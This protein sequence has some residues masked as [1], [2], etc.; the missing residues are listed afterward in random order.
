ML[1][2]FVQYVSYPLWERANGIRDLA[3]LRQLMAWEKLDAEGLRVL[4]RE[5]LRA[6]L[7]H[8]ND[9]VPFYREWFAAHGLR[10]QDFGEVDA[11]RL[12][13]PLTKSAISAAG[14]QMISTSVP[15]NTVRRD[16]TGGST[17]EPLYFY[18]NEARKS[19]VRALTMRENLWLGCR[20]GDRIA[21]FWGSGKD[22]QAPATFRNTMSAV[23]VRRHRVFNAYQLTD[24][25]VDHFL[26]G[27]DSY[28]PVLIVAYARAMYAAACRLQ[29]TGRTPYRPK[30]IVI[31]AESVSDE[32][33]DVIR[34][35]FA[36]PVVNRYAS[37]EVGQVASGCGRSSLLHVNDESVVVQLEPL[38]GAAAGDAGRLVTTDLAN[39]VMPL[40]RYDTGDH[41][42]PAV[43]RC[44]CGRPSTVLGGVEGRI[45]DLFARVDGGR[46][47]G[48]AFVHLFRQ[49]QAIKTFQ[50]VQ[51]SLRDVEV[52]LVLEAPL[53][54]AEWQAIE[55]GIR[56][57]LGSRDVG[58]RRS[59]C[60]TIEPPISGKH[61]FAISRV[62]ET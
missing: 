40:I 27:L 35:A 14:E 57:L 30:A 52:R 6:A 58:I 50:I 45:L 48:L 25:K 22:F 8:A 5:R 7:N 49:G 54:A 21:R 17:G 62:C 28:R 60:P 13:P 3:T 24:E 12:L 42:I 11:L 10:E 33:R 2:T 37:R 29:R 23:L 56:A 18:V 16:S 1:Q 19:W 31:T 41:G 53:T 46:V 51:H 39:P 15:R 55:D 61:R 32:E 26:D 59:D 4:Q 20:P 34:E 9:T 47:P 44:P 36:V 43:A 38:E